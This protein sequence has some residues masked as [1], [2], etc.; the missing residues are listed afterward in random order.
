MVLTVMIKLSTFFLEGEIL[1]Q[2]SGFWK[3]LSSY[4]F[5]ALTLFSYVLHYWFQ[6][7]IDILSNQ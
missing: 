5:Q 4:Q 1:E 2:Q 7:S 6:K 3:V